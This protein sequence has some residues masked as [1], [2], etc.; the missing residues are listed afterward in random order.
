[1]HRPSKLALAATTAV[2]TLVCPSLADTPAAGASL[3]LAW[4][5]ASDPLQQFALRSGTVTDAA[6]GSLCVTMSAPYPAALTLQPCTPGE[7]SQA[8]AFNTSTAWPDAFTNPT[9]WGGGGC[10]LWNTQG[11]P[12]YEAAG[13]TVGVYACS[14]P[15]PFDS[16]FAVGVPAPGLLAATM[17]EPGNATF[18]NLCMAAAN[19]VPPPI[20]SPE[21]VAWAA[22]EMACFIHFNMAT[23]AGTQGCGGCSQAPPPISKWAPSALDTDAW[24]DAGVAMGCTRFVYVAKHGCGFAAWPSNATVNGERYPYST[25]FAPN[26]TDVV[27]AFVASCQK[28]SVG[29]G[30]YYSVGSNALLNVQGGSV[31]SSS[32]VPGQ[33]AVTKA[34]FDRVV[35]QQLTELWSTFGPLAEVWFDGGYTSDQAPVL[36]QL[37]AALQPRVVAFGAAGLCANPARW[38]G[39]E[40]GYAPYPCW[41]TVASVGDNGAGDPNGALWVPAETDFTLQ[42]GGKDR[43][44][45]EGGAA[46]R[47][48]SRVVVPPAWRPLLG[49]AVGMRMCDGRV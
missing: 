14:S 43:G 23:A 33:I 3:V 37:F 49:I 12:G 46:G 21:I 34:E 27:S 6:T 8:W 13:S 9:A 4:C 41:S 31:C 17:T 26:T 19:P 44:E 30:F 32:P 48:P 22:H 47:H 2:A 15:T 25:A 39:T 11:G 42:V 24:V 18:S 7:P 20:P 45:A 35:V 1:M 40:S 5:N 10:A 16:V 29:Y 28:R 38:V 36:R